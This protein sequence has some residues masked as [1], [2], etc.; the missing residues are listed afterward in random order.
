MEQQVFW[1]NILRALR[2]KSNLTQKEVAGFI[3]VTRQT[4]SGYETG[5]IHP[6][7]ECIAL[8]SEI[9]DVELINYVYEYLPESFVQEAKEFKARIPELRQQKRRARARKK[10]VEIRGLEDMFLEGYDEDEDL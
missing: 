5:R 10:K 7:P 4:Y 6:T 8:L 3:G 1:G 9:Y 2:E